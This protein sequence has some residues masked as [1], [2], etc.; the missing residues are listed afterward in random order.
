MAGFSAHLILAA[1]LLTSLLTSCAL[2]GR[3]GARHA[4]LDWR[5]TTRND[6]RKGRTSAVHVTHMSKH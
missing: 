6:C 2:F 4:Y 3:L 5:G 1:I